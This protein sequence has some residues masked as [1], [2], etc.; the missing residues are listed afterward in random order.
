MCPFLKRTSPSTLRTLSTATRP[1]TGGGTMSNLQVLAR[2][3]PVMSKALAVQSARMSGTKRFTSCAAGV[4]SIK[5]YKAPTGN[6]ALHTTRG[7]PASVASES[8][9]KNEQGENRLPSSI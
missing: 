8:Y 7:H 6:R 2:R 1:S 9:E 5:P 3:C 4:P